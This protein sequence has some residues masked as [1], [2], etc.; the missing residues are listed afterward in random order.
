MK[1]IVKMEMEEGDRTST[2]HMSAA[3]TP[4][5]K[6]VRPRSSQASPIRKTAICRA[7]LCQECL[8]LKTDLETTREKVMDL[9]YKLQLE[10][11]KHDQMIRRM[12]EQQ[13]AMLALAYEL[14]EQA[15]PEDISVLN[16]LL[17]EL[18][19]YSSELRR[20]NQ[21]LK[22]Q[23]TVFRGL[24]E[25]KIEAEAVFRGLFAEDM[26]KLEEGYRADIE[27]LDQEYVRCSEASKVKMHG[28]QMLLELS[29]RLIE[30]W[31]T[32][33]SVD[34]TEADMLAAKLEAAQQVY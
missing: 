4:R 23:V 28:L 29:T 2:R 7:F 24:I 15:I 33:G 17:V 13:A 9:G 6:G 10:R 8:R 27:A 25:G 12:E 31:R 32:S 1:D 34:D 19:I 11:E 26:V 14:P 16:K 20:E 22:T 30:K 3:S 18:Q 5:D 21:A